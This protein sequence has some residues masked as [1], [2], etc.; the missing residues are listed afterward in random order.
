MR[1]ADM[2]YPVPTFKGTPI[3]LDDV[4]IIQSPF[5]Y[6]GHRTRLDEFFVE[7]TKVTKKNVY[8]NKYE[9]S[10]NP[11]ASDKKCITLKTRNHKVR[12]EQIVKFYKTNNLANEIKYCEQEVTNLRIV[13]QICKNPV[14]IHSGIRL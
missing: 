1:R 3:Q 11:Y 9:I 6:M 8:G 12:L 2:E 13:E 7:L 5:Y 10:Q 14:P 4:L